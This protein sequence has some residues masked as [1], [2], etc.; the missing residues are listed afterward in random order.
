MKNAIIDE[1]LNNHTAQKLE[2]VTKE[3]D[4]LL[5]K[6]IEL[7]GKLREK[8]SSEQYALVSEYSE[9]LEICN[10]EQLDSYFAEGFS[11]ALRIC[12]ECFK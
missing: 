1:I 10:C 8:L 12:F 4:L 2:T 9:A 11:C 5:D 3:Y 6:P 7:L